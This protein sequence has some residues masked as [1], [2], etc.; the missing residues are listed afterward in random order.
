MMHLWKIDRILVWSKCALK[1]CFDFMG[2]CCSDECLMFWIPVIVSNLIMFCLLFHL[3]WI[4][5][6]CFIHLFIL[7]YKPNLKNVSELNLR[8]FCLIT[9]QLNCAKT[10]YLCL[11]QVVFVVVYTYILWHEWGDHSSLRNIFQ[12]LHFVQQNKR[13][14]FFASVEIWI[15]CRLRA[16]RLYVGLEGKF[17]LILRCGKMYYHQGWELYY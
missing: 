10:K 6:F 7:L 8:V 2:F 11:V 14:N 5:R 17:S 1:V 3:I 4:S 9:I 13:Q 16:F 15:I 12:L